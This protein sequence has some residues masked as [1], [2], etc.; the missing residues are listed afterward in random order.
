MLTKNELKYYSLLI[1]KKHRAAEK[2]FIIE[3]KKLTEEGLQSNYKSEI[4][5]CTNQFFQNNQVFIRSLDNKKIRLEVIKNHEFQKLS[6]TR[7]PQGIAS[8]FHF[9]SMS[10]KNRY[11]S[12]IIVALDNINDPGNL[13]TIIRT[14]DWFGVSDILLSDDTADIYNPKVL[15]ATMGSVFHIRFDYRKNLP[16]NFN[17]LKENGYKILTADLNGENVFNY[18]IKEKSVIVFS[19]E[20]HGPSAST[21]SATDTYITIPGKGKA[22][23]LNVASSAA[24]ILSQ[25]TF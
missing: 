8:V 1:E 12:K 7:N 22:E 25:L 6:D 15:R 11:E 3:G 9:P 21:R 19:N 2:K 5:I 24:V 10:E 17:L 13:G 20:T 18:N 14:C 23:S 4:I 16:E